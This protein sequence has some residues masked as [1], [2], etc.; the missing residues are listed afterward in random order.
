MFALVGVVLERGQTQNLF[1]S[2]FVGLSKANECKRWYDGLKL[3]QIADLLNE[4]AD[5]DFLVIVREDF[6]YRDCGRVC[7]KE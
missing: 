7:S 3:T 2:K 4:L 6:E 1:V 5:F